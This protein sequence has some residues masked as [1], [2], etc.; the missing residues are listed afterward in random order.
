MKHKLM[1]ILPALASIPLAIAECPLAESSGCL[2]KKGGH[3]MY[4]WGLW[5]LA[6]IIIGAFIFSVIFWLVYKWL[7]GGC[8][9]Q[10]KTTKKKKKK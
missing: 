10:G 2:A 1:Y 4:S 3:M 5:K 8:C 9:C 7:V 6:Y